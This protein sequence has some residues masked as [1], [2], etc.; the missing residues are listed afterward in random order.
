MIHPESTM[1]AEIRLLRRR[2]RANGGTAAGSPA[3]VIRHCFKDARG[4]ARAVR[5]VVFRDLALVAEDS[6]SA[7]LQVEKHGF[8]PDAGNP[9]ITAIWPRI[10]GRSRGLG[11]ADKRLHGPLGGA[12]IVF[13]IP[14]GLE[15]EFVV[16]LL[17][18]HERQD[19][20]EPT[21]SLIQGKIGTG[22]R[23]A[24]KRLSCIVVVPKSEGELFEITRTL[25]TR[26][27]FAHSSGHRQTHGDDY[28]N[29]DYNN[30]NDLQSTHGRLPLFLP[31]MH[32]LTTDDR[33]Q[34]FRIGDVISLGIREDVA[35]ENQQIGEFAHL[36]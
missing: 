14:T 36:Q 18:L 4:V 12:S 22:N 8:I 3:A 31:L 19:G 6:T 30:E 21:Q 32:N 23:G 25:R 17:L 24:R 10:G 2:H 35:G 15:I 1:L 34:H 33:D 11:G 16:K 27:G 26:S 7:V 29:H 28:H 13:R 9:H 20:D 5:D